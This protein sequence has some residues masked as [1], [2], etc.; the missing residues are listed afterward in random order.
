MEDGVEVAVL[1]EQ[2]RQLSLWKA[3]F[4][5]EFHNKM[6]DLDKTIRVLIAAR[7][8]WTTSIVISFLSTLCGS[9]LMYILT[10]GGK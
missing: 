2:V 5:E 6:D 4:L 7:P 3:D 8:S 9:M 1:K 10:L